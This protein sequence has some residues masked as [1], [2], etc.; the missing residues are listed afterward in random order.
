MAE[1]FTLSISKKNQLASSI[2]NKWKHSGVNISDIFCEFVIQ[3][4]K[5]ERQLQQQAS[6]PAQQS[7]PVAVVEEEMIH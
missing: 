4:D 1:T 3:Y 2:I 7:G 5:K 6:A